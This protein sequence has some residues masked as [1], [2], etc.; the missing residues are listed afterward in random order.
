MYWERFL[1][2]AARAGLTGD[3]ATASAAAAAVPLGEIAHM[4]PPGLDL[5]DPVRGFAS[6][7]RLCRSGAEA[8]SGCCWSMIFSG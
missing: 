7:A 3:R 4:I 6:V 8:S 2:L 5:P 1:A